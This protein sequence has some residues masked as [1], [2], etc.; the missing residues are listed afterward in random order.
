[1]FLNVV[2]NSP[3][4]KIFLVITPG[5]LHLDTMLLLSMRFI[6]GT[7]LDNSCRNSLAGV[8]VS[9]NSTLS[10]T[11]NA[12]GFYSF[13][14]NQGTLDLTATSYITYYANSSTISTIGKAVVKHDIELVKK[15]KG[16]IS[17]SVTS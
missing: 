6:N 8:T 9:A 12:T 5:K 3:L 7:V 1:M 17:G 16:N 10:T 2:E 11:S 13:A 15:P 14:V 4:R